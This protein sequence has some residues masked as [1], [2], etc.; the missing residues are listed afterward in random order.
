MVASTDISAG[1]I[2]L[3]TALAVG[4]WYDE[5]GVDINATTGIT[6][7]G[8]ATAFRTRATKTGADQCYMDSNGYL[9]AGGGNVVL[10]AAGLQ[11]YGQY[12]AFYYGAFQVGTIYGY[13]ASTLAI[14]GATRF[15]SAA[16]FLAALTVAGKL[17]VGST[18]SFVLPRRSSAPTSPEE[19]EMY[20]DSDDNN[21]YAYID[22]DLADAT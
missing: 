13:D 10:S 18:G 22:G 8:S 14:S 1:H 2:L 21:I 19:G 6:I 15:A 3:S 17:K 9:C 5:A 7:Y 11:I 20:L 4:D 16:N 12:L